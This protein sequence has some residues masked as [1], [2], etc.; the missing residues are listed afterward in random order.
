MS[1]TITV[2]KV[3]TAGTTLDVLIP[4]QPVDLF[5]LPAGDKSGGVGLFLG[6]SGATVASVVVSTTEPGIAKITVAGGEVPA[7]IPVGAKIQ[8]FKTAQPKPTGG[9]VVGGKKLTLPKNPKTNV[10]ASLGN[11]SYALVMK[12]D[13]LLA[14]QSSGKQTEYAIGWKDLSKFPGTTKGPSYINTAVVS[15]VAAFGD[16]AAV[17]ED[18]VFGDAASWFFRMGGKDAEMGNY[19]VIKMGPMTG[20]VPNYGAVENY[21]VMSKAYPFDLYYAKSENGRPPDAVLAIPP[22]TAD[23]VKMWTGGGWSGGRRRGSR[24]GSRRGRRHSRAHKRSRSSRR[25]H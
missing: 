14:A 17:K 19:M 16:A 25:R 2:A 1:N 24:R 12:N 7:G 3:T 6:T 11:F 18:P 21:T 5:G 22:T 9:P 4:A 8:Y 13:E 23:P 10:T 15:R 20:F